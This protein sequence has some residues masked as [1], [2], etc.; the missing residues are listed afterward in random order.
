M[1]TLVPQ[2]AFFALTLASTVYFGFL[3]ADT[4]ART[5]GKGRTAETEG[6]VVALDKKFAKGPR[7]HI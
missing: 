2:L 7:T 3:L 6:N 1:T 4:L 5:S